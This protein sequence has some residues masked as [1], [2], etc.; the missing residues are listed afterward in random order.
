MPSHKTDGAGHFLTRH[1]VDITTRGLVP[2]MPSNQAATNPAGKHAPFHQGFVWAALALALGVGF[3]I[4]AHL[5]FVLGFGFPV[6]KGFGSFVQ[7]HGHAQLLGWAG[8]MIMGISVH[9]IP[10]LT[11]VPLA[12]P[13]WRKPLLWLLVTGLWLRSVGHSSLPYVTNSAVAT[14]V[15]G[16]VVAAGIGESLGILAYVWLVLRTAW[17]APELSQHLAL[18]SVRPY[19]GMML[20]GWVV[21]GVGNVALLGHMALTDNVVLHPLW[22]HWMV[23]AFQGLVLLPVALAFSV[24][25]FPLYLRL[26]VPEWSVRGLAY[27]YA[28]AL[29]AE[30]GPAVPALWSTASPTTQGVSH[31]GMVVKGMTIL[32]FVWKLDVLTRR[33]APWTTRRQLHPGPER[34]ATRPGLPD[35]GEFGRFERLVYAA[36]VWLVVAAACECLT[37]LL[38]LWQWPT[39]ISPAAIRH[40]YLLGF[41]TLLIFGMAVRMLPGFVHKRRIVYPSLVEATFWLG[42][43]AVVSRVFPWILPATLLQSFP[44]VASVAR[45]AF[46][47]SGL[48][49]LL[50]V[51]CLGLNL[52]TTF[53]KG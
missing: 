48:L 50:A 27:V 12:H 39:L 4:G 10:R 31:L 36:Y 9:F 2:S 44:G 13:G 11:G 43:A 32:W 24:R 51:L 25:M 16:L 7:T 30:L 17:G 8:L 38:A 22:N 47:V 23:Q 19:F 52:W 28:G 5:T 41:I 45:L 33:R 14:A 15:T 34:R 42:N 21:Y 1:V 29:L 37:G 18:R 6:S 49:G 40:M 35:Y 3:A 46:A 26:A 20:V 53:R